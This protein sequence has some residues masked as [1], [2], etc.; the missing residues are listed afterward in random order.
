MA[1][2]QGLLADPQ[3]L[4]DVVGV[5]VD[6]PMMRARLKAASRRFLGAVRP[7]S[8][9]PVDGAT[10]WLNGDGSNVLLLPVC[11]VRAVHAVEAEGQALAEDGFEWSEEG[12][13]KRLER[14]PDR[15]RSVE[16]TCDHGFTAVP[17]DV[18]EVVLDQ[19]EATYNIKKGVQ[20]LSVDGQ[21]VTFGTQSAVGVT[22]AWSD[23]VER[24]SLR[25]DRA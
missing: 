20:S 7:V 18:Q 10:F 22:Q 11:P 21:A 15:L 16:V 13:L 17:D 23:A 24:Y 9:T 1:I 5:P 2:P 4:A 8:F 6:D 12:V 19:A 25:G 14:W 3:D